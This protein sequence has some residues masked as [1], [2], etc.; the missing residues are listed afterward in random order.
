MEVRKR[1]N[2]EKYDYKLQKEA[3]EHSKCPHSESR[4]IISGPLQIVLSLT[5]THTKIHMYL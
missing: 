3:L 2:T 5:H 1:V 4:K